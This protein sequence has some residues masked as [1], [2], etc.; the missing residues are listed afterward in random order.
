LK[1]DALRMGDLA[2]V[3]LWGNACIKK[4]EGKD[5]YWMLLIS[6]CFTGP[7]AYYLSPVCITWNTF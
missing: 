6:L 3:R 7:I 4:E 2:Q 5:I 1:A